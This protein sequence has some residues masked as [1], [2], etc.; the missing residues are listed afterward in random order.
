MQFLLYILL[1]P[2]LFLI[3]ILPFRLL[4]IFSDCVYILVYRIIGY[5]KKTVRE[6]LAL[7][8][9]HLSEKER[10]LIEKK[11]YKHLCDMFLEMIK[12]MTISVKEIEKRFKFKNIDYYLELEKEGKSIALMCGHYASYEWS[13]SINSQ[14]TFDGFAIYKRIN[15]KYFDDL[16]KKIRSRFKAYLITTKETVPTIESNNEKGVKGL[17]GFASDQSPQVKQKTYWSNFMGIEVPVYTGAEMLAKKFDMNIMFMKIKK[18][19]RGFYEAEL[20]LL[21]NDA[22]SVPD[23]EITEIFLRKVEQQIL[24]APEF[25]LWT[26][27]RWKHRNKKPQ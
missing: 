5:R 3:S 9:P 20:E 15:N 21:T 19:K 23:Y 13:I 11:S 1:Y 10:L 8:L 2:I 7:A 16:V 26:H 12:T 22:K 24:E 17:Y 27:K 14:I 6:N 4:Y 18:V 25:Y